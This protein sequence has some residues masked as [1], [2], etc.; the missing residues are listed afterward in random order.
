MENEEKKNV[1]TDQ[2]PPAKK[3]CACG[4]L[5]TFFIALLTSLIVVAGYHMARQTVRCFIRCSARSQQVQQMRQNACPCPCP[6]RMR[7]FRQRPGFAPGCPG[8][9]RFDRPRFPGK[10]GMNK[11]GF[12]GKRGRFGK[13]PL[14]PK[15]E[16]KPAPAPQA[17]AAAPA[18]P[19]TPAKK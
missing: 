7:Q 12:P 2:N 9:Q 16:V 10:P 17:P 13:K 4:D 19:E 1:C 5:R 3:S 11:P 15:D 14:P 6:C 8:E 18:K